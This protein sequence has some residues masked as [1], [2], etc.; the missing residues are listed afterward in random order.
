M[1]WKLKIWRNSVNEEIMREMTLSISAKIEN[2]ASSERSARNTEEEKQAWLEADTREERK[3]LKSAN[4]W[5]KRLAISRKLSTW[6]S[7]LRRNSIENLFWKW[8]RRENEENSAAEAQLRNIAKWRCAWRRLRRLPRETREK[9][10]NTLT[11]REAETRE[12]E[13]R[14]YRRREEKW[15]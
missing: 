15:S 8:R 1:K 11:W 4:V 5:R 13:K 9:P 3:L 2:T 10:A 6:N 12:E 7:Y 14:Q